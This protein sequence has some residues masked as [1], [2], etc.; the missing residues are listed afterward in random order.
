MSWIHSTNPVVDWLKGVNSGQ[1]SS[2][3][4]VEEP[5]KRSEWILVDTIDTGYYYPKPPGG[6]GLWMSVGESG[7]IGISMFSTKPSDK[8]STLSFL[9]SSSPTSPITLSSFT[10]KIYYNPALI[11]LSGREYLMVVC[12]NDRNIHLWD[13]VNRTSRVVYQ[14]GSGR[15]KHMILCVKDNETVIF[16]EREHTD[17]IHKV[18]LLNTSTDQWSPRTT[19][20]LQI[21]LV[22][23]ADM[24][25]A[26][27]SDGTP[28]LVL[29]NSL[30]P[31]R[32]VVV[33]EIVGGEIRWRLG[34]ETIGEGFYPFR[35]CT[36]S[37]HN[38]YVCDRG[39]QRVYMLSSD[40]GSV[41][42]TVLNSQ[43]HGIFDP[44]CIQ[45][46]NDQM[47]VSHLNNLNNK[48]WMISKF[49]RK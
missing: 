3:A 45:I 41:I 36:D 30:G 31:T 4:P 5:T 21:G 10:E 42:R 13:T 37:E 47:Y 25:Y 20:R 15:G 18:S 8:F 28:C 44:C 40:D 39:R 32:S 43:Q 34:V 19:L 22:T 46:H 17:G 14:E 2:S 33:V 23:I 16:G 7:N 29:C 49:A 12:W 9:H 24:C 38:V 11:K 48:K 35:V 26:Q 1:A 6:S 27:L